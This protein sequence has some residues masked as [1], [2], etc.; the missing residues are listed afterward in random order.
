[1]HVAVRVRGGQKYYRNGRETEVVEKGSVILDCWAKDSAGVLTI[2][3]TT[4]STLE[5]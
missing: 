5:L 4:G 3:S 2:Y 1:M